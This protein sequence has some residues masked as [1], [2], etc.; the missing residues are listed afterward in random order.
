MKDVEIK[1]LHGC[2]TEVGPSVDTVYVS[3]VSGSDD[4]ASGSFTPAQARELAAA[5]LKAADEAEGVEHIDSEQAVRN[6]VAAELET[7]P[8]YNDIA[9]WCAH[10][11]YQQAIYTARNGLRKGPR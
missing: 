3:S 4:M 8:R 1:G 9:D 11:G 7:L 6:K 5:L 10:I 2:Y